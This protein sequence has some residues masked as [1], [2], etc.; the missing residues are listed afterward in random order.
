MTMNIRLAYSIPH[1]TYAT[2]M[3]FRPISKVDSLVPTR[4]SEARFVTDYQ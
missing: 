1:T 3:A 4:K 2:H